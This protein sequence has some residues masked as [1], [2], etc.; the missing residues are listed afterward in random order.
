MLAML[1]ALRRHWPEYLMEAALLG[2]FK[3]SACAFA[4][5]LEYPDSPVR[6]ALPGGTVRR[7]FAALAMGGTV[8]AL[9]S[10]PWGKRFGAHINPAVTLAFLR[11][12]QGTNGSAVILQN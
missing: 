6:Q 8:I 7:V 5:L 4:V 1:E 12:G 11:L 3:V 9:F 2:L 10:S